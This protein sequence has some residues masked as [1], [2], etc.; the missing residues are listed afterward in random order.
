MILATGI[1]MMASSCDRYDDAE[2]FE[3]SSGEDFYR[4]DMVMGGRGIEVDVNSNGVVS[5]AEYGYF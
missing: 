2:Y 1:V 4:F 3:L 5:Q